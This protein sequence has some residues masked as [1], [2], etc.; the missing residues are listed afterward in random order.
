M[1]KEVE[2]RSDDDGR[3]GDIESGPAVERE[4]KVEEIDYMSAEEAV[5]GIAED[6]ATD[7]AKAKLV[8]RPLEFEAAP[9]N[10]HHNEDENRERDQQVAKTLEK[11]PCGSVVNGIDQIEETGNHLNATMWGIGTEGKATPVDNHPFGK[12]VEE[13]DGREEAEEQA[14]VGQSCGDPLWSWWVG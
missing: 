13:E 10:D 12:L 4:V 11:A 6:A 9:E 2:E 8:S 1:P 5:D 3:V 7:E 14:I